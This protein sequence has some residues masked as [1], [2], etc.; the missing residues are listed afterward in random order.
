M[1]KIANAINEPNKN[2]AHEFE[3]AT[4]GMTFEDSTAFM[5]SA[6]PTAMLG[7]VS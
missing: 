5:D 2:Q 3:I 1:R 6:A 7:A 4:E